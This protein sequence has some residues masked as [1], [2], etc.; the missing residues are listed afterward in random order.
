MPTEIRKLTPAFVK[1]VK[2]APA[3][4]RLEIR[5][6]EVAHFALRITDRGT[7]SFIVA[8]RWPGAKMTIKRTIGDA[9]VMSLADARKV[10]RSWLELAEKGIDPQVQARKEAEAEARD[11]GT[12]FAALAEDFIRED[13][14][15]KRRGGADAREIRREILPRWGKLPATSINAG[16]VIELAKELK[17]K[18]ATGRLVL[19][20]TKRIFAWALHEHDK[21]HGN[22]YG[23]TGNP[24]ADI[25]PRRLF[26]EKRPR[27]RNLDDDEL[28]AL[29]VACR[30]IPYPIG[31]CVEL[32]LLTGCRREEI[33]GARWEEVDLDKR[34]FVVPPERF[35]SGVSHIVP[36][37]IDATALLEKLPRHA[38]PFIFST[39]GER[40]ING[41][42]KA[43]GEI[44]R[45][46]ARELGREPEHWVLHDLRHT[47]RT[48]MA[49]LGVDDNV[50]EMVLGHAKRGLGR[51]YNE[52]RYEEE[53]RAAYEKWAELLRAIVAPP[54]P[55]K[56]IPL[57]RAAGKLGWIK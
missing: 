12:T 24:A 11:R 13:L 4:K 37:G 50:A 40:P 31:P 8:K 25:S 35:K 47:I 36:L 2:P 14:A 33:S 41:W 9:G 29:L 6:T 16:H 21:V 48:R 53:M 51:V 17:H 28:R 54:E 55:G 26:G 3:G 7:K 22:R 46:M 52:H 42:S 39:S 10:A 44:D 5:D 57:K 34:R 20:H 56:V 18:A 49:A 15:D 30:E 1:S 27:E 32:L 43:K 45:V 38:G 23:L 19:S